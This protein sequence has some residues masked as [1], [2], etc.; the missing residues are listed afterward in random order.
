MKTNSVA[1]PAQRGQQT[2]LYMLTDYA[3]DMRWKHGSFG[4]HASTRRGRYWYRK[5]SKALAKAH[6]HRKTFIWWS[7]L[8]SE[9][10]VLPNTY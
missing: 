9:A 10:P 5:W 7:R 3:L 6:K 2:R 8:A 1:T 4:V